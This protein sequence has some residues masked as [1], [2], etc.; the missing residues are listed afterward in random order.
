M[1]FVWDNNGNLIQDDTRFYGYDHSNRLTF[2]LMDGDTYNF[3][4]NGLGDRLRQTVNGMPTNYWL[5]INSG[6][7]QVLED[8]R[9]AYLY[10]AGRIGEEQPGGWKYPLGD[11]LGSVRQITDLASDVMLAQGYKPFGSVLSTTGDVSTNYGFTGEW[12]DGSDLIHLR[13]RYYSPYLNQWI[14]PDP[15][16]PDPYIP[17]DWNRYAYV[18]NNPINYTDPSGMAPPSPW[19]NRNLTDWLIRE[20]RANSASAEVYRIAYFND[21][22]RKLVSISYANANA[23][24]AAAFKGFAYDDWIRLVATGHRWDFKPGIHLKLDRRD[25]VALCHRDGCEWYEYSVPGNIHYAFVGRAAGFSPDELHWGASYAEV[26]DI[27]HRKL[28]EDLGRW[29]IEYHTDLTCFSRT[30]RIDLFVNLEWWETGFDDPADFAAVSMG[31]DLYR[32][33]S[34]LGS[35]GTLLKLYSPRLSHMPEPPAPFR[36]PSWPYPLGYFDGSGG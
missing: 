28:F 23:P 34:G 1:S 16:V 15:I 33:P 26:T 8:G 12:T 29:I 14:Q 35:F 3:A 21:V 2:V 7:T 32:S 4:Y 9:S 36:N 13:T 27:A 18:R 20:M 24:L 25:T 31:V 11:A 17:A 6:L 19:D 10:G 30:L 22:A 5:D